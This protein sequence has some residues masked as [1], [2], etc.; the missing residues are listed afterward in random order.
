M[1][2]TMSITAVAVLIL[3]PLLVILCGCQYNTTA[4]TV[5]APATVPTG[6]VVVTVTSHA[7]KNIPVTTGS[8]NELG[9]TAIKAAAAIVGGG[10]GAALGGPA[11]AAVGA[12][13]GFVGAEA[14]QGASK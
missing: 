10:A 1:R 3:W 7:D 6:G 8:S 14:I 5:T 12:G 4:V 9:D 13:A 2:K 11:G